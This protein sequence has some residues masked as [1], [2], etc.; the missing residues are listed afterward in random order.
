MLTEK[1]SSKSFRRTLTR[2]LHLNCGFS[3]EIQIISTF[4]DSLAGFFQNTCT[5]KTR[6]MVIYL[7]LSYEIRVCL[8]RES[9]GSCS[10]LLSFFEALCSRF[11][12]GDGAGASNGAGCFVK[13]NNRFFLF[14]SIFHVSIDPQNQ[15]FERRLT[16][17]IVSKFKLVLYSTAHRPT[18]GLFSFKREL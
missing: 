4:V 6:T 8:Q 13:V 17:L 10:S 9:F 16:L 15:R 11:G 12:D 14:W 7:C 1:K 5:Q 18:L 3:T 2:Y